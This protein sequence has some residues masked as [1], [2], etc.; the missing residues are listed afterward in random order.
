MKNVLQWTL[1]IIGLGLQFFV[2]SA[3]FSGPIR[4]YTAVFIY[5]VVLFLTTVIEIV[6]A[7]D[8]GRITREWSMVFWVCEF[9]RQGA[10][11]AVVISFVAHAVP[12]DR[13]KSAVGRLLIFLALIFWAGSFYVQ[14]SD[15]VTLWMTNALRNLSFCSAIVNLGLWFVLIASERRDQTLL[16]VTGA[17]GLQMTGEAIGQSLRQLSRSTLW[18]GNM[19]AILTHFLCLYIWWQAFRRAH[20]GPPPAGGV[21]DLRSS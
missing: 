3:L 21:A 15:N 20:P 16:M 2:I 5:S 13:Q 8:R 11:Y 4:E 19:T 18:L 12:N 14:R 1:W 10:M 6:A 17:L 7:L 9:I